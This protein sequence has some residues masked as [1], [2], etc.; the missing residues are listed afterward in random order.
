MPTSLPKPSGTPKGPRPP[1]VT[2]PKPVSAW[3]LMTGPEAAY[4]A[5]R[6]TCVAALASVAAASAPGGPHTARCVDAMKEVPAAVCEGGVRYIQVPD[7]GRFPEH[8]R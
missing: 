7:T 1:R 6:W 4:E 3:A 2:F 8:Y 5:V